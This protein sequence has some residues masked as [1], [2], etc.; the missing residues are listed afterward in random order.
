MWLYPTNDVRL[1]TKAATEAVNR[2]F[3]GGFKHTE[4]EALLMDLQ[5]PGEFNDD[6][7]RAFAA[8]DGRQG[9]E[10]FG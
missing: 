2:L 9:D 1:I 8:C 10:R 5:Q 4:A 3:R 7:V 6:I